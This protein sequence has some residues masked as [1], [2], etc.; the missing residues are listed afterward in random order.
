MLLLIVLVRPQ[1]QLRVLSTYFTGDF[2]FVL[3]NVGTPGGAVG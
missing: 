3:C 1:V 2:G